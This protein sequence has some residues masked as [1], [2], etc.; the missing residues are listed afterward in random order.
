MFEWKIFFPL[1]FN[2]YI[3]NK[4][5]NEE[6]EKSYEFKRPESVLDNGM[7][8]T[9]RLTF[10]TT[11]FCVFWK[12]VKNIFW[13]PLFFILLDEKIERKKPEKFT[14]TKVKDKQTNKNEIIVIIIV[15][16]FLLSKHSNYI[17]NE[18]KKNNKYFHCINIT[19][20]EFCFWNFHSFF[21]NW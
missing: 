15:N 17:S 1:F 13:I 19:S 9:K 20:F 7:T 3:T 21:T 16:V 14:F 11:T 18:K 2:Y 4:Q 8:W 5:T 6:N 12:K 10:T